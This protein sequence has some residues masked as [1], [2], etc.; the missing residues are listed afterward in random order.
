MPKV[1]EETD[2]H[3]IVNFT[4]ECGACKGTGLYVGMAER[5]GAAVICTRCDGT[6]RVV[7]QA[8]YPKFKG[9]KKR[10]DVRRV[11]H[12]AGGYGIT[13]QD[14]TT[15]K[16]ETIHFSRF[17]CSYEDWL[18]GD[19]P[20]PIEELHCPYIHTNQSM[21]DRDHEAYPL[22]KERCNQEAL[23]GGWISDCKLFNKKAECWLRY[24]QLVEEK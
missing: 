4:K 12:T 21:Q 15:E 20:K 8:S 6:G 5:D 16:G 14:I 7:H 10:D 18:K 2:T 9:R 3:V 24:Y 23:L 11:Y 17:G 1:L 13:T 22:Y 19:K